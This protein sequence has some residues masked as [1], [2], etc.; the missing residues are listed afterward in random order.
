M[1]ELPPDTYLSHLT[2]G[3]LRIKIPS[4]K[5]DLSY[6]SRL[7]DQLSGVP[8]V[9]RV[10]VNPV[11]GSL[12][13]IHSLETDA[14]SSFLKDHHLLKS[15]PAGNSTVVHREATKLFRSVDCQV[16]RFTG[17]EVN[18]GS[19]ASLAL[20]G[21]GIYQILRGNFTAIPWYSAFWYGL[22]IFLKSKPEG[23]A[24]DDGE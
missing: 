7:K 6:F 23:N 18:L 9:E 14:V 4:K 10:D 20:V 17:G 15:Q 8:G 19:L 3:R 22:S 1:F 13:V 12:L 21:A 24:L 11:T 16:K 2:A 5:G